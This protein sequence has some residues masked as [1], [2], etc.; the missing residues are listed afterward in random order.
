MKTLTMDL[1]HR[2]DDLSDMIVGKE[3]DRKIDRPFVIGG[4]WGSGRSS[5]MQALKPRLADLGLLPVLVSPPP[6]D[7]DTGAAALLQIGEALQQQGL[8]DGELAKLEDPQRRWHEKLATT[9]DWV[10]Q[11]KQDL[12][13]LC[14]EVDKWTVPPTADESFSPYSNRHVQELANAIHQRIH[15]RRVLTSSLAPTSNEYHRYDL[16]RD[17]H[18]SWL[19]LSTDTWGTDLGPLAHELYSRL[20]ATLSVASPLDIRLLVALAAVTAVAEVAVFYSQWPDCHAIVR[21]SR[22]VSAR[23]VRSLAAYGLSG[24][25]WP[26]AGRRWRK[27][28]WIFSAR[29]GL[30]RG[31][32]PFCTTACCTDARAGTS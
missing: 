20:G 5:L 18:P 6:R 31:N 12:V 15:C 2:A 21:N 19:L 16:P 25:N 8:I 13:L 1:N 30:N 10:D 27:N 14:E 3:F 23:A 28:C 11:N 22:Q 9:L 4:R 7:M 17:S 32:R 29:G 24:L 26:C